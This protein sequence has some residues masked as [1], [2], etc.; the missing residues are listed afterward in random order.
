[1][2]K[3]DELGIVYYDWQVCRDAEAVWVEDDDDR[4]IT[5]TMPTTNRESDAIAELV[6]AAPDLYEAVRRLLTYASDEA[7]WHRAVEFAHRAIEKAGG[8]E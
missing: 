4:E 8:A 3:I 5:I 1:M 6:S 7:N 2:K